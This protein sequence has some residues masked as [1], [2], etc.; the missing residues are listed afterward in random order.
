MAISQ[1]C[2]CGGTAT[3][4]NPECERCRLVHTVQAAAKVRVCQKAYFSLRTGQL[5]EEAQAAEKYLDRLLRRLN[6]IQ[7][8]LFDCEDA[9]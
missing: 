7:P 3:D 2:A 6:Q 8:T 4:I 1:T 9:E 5:L